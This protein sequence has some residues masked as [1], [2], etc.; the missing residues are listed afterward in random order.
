MFDSRIL[1]PTAAQAQAGCWSCV[2]LTAALAGCL[3]GELVL[4]FQ[5]PGLDRVSPASTSGP[6][7]VSRPGAELVHVDSRPGPDSDSESVGLP[8]PGAAELRPGCGCD[9]AS[10]PA[11]LRRFKFQVL[12]KALRSGSPRLRARPRRRARRPAAESRAG[13]SWIRL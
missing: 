5:R 4:S 2:P 3:D 6:I 12:G 7:V 10:E 13:P 1:F 11:T 8:Q 9:S